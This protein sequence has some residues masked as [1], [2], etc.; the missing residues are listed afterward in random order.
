M[1]RPPKQKPDQRQL[2]YFNSFASVE[3]TLTPIMLPNLHGSTAQR[4]IIGHLLSPLSGA[5]QGAREKD[6]AGLK[7]YIFNLVELDRCR[8]RAG[9]RPPVSMSMSA[10]RANELSK[11]NRKMTR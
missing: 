3:F 11:D 2:I 4:R 7:A 9:T 6:D 10:G 1:A 8:K 5:Q